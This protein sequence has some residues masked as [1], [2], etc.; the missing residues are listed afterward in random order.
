MKHFLNKQYIS[1]YYQGETQKTSQG[2]V[3]VIFHPKIYFIKKIK[4]IFGPP[5]FSLHCIPLFKW[6]CCHKNLHYSNKIYIYTYYYNVK[7]FT[8]HCSV[9]CIAFN[10][11]IKYFNII[12]NKIKK[13][14]TKKF[15]MNENET[16][17]GI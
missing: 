11:L 14:N 13:Y 9:C 1:K 17:W 10:V 5:F 3:Q 12:Y 4:P 6:N 2:N 7:A 16:F 15:E 8:D